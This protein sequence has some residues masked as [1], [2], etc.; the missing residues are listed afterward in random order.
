MRPDSS[1][2]QE[3]HCVH[4][5]PS[6]WAWS[7][8]SNACST[9]RRTSSAAARR[10][11]VSSSAWRTYATCASRKTMIEPPEVLVFGP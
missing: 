6:N 5:V 2:Y 11:A 8:R 3:S 7:R 1:R 4:A 9:S 10:R